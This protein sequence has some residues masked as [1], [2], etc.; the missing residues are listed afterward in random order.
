MDVSADTNAHYNNSNNFMHWYNGSNACHNMISDET[1]DESNESNYDDFVERSLSL[2]PLPI[3][4]DGGSETSPNAYDGQ[5]IPEVT[6][7]SR[8]NHTT[9]RNQ[10]SQIFC[11]IK[12]VSD[13]PKSIED[14]MSSTNPAES[15]ATMK[16]D[17]DSIMTNNMWLLAVRRLWRQWVQDYFF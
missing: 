16:K 6:N 17:I 15:K 3:E 2:L 13:D 7:I 14:A 10:K 9:N 8:P 11:T 5:N 4:I 1:D 12:F